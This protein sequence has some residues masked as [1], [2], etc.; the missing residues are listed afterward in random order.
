[1]V[2]KKFSK[3][4]RTL[5]EQFTFTKTLDKQF[6]TI[7]SNIE[8]YELMFDTLTQILEVLARVMKSNELLTIEGEM[9]VLNDTFW[10]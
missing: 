2:A 9:K 6:E 5:R 10:L 4:E 7:G 1:M 3:A 8:T